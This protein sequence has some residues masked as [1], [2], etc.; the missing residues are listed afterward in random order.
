VVQFL[1]SDSSAC[2]VNIKDFHVSIRIIDPGGEGKIVDD[3]N[4]QLP[5]G[6]V[7]VHSIGHPARVV[8]N[9]IAEGLADF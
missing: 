5:S 4:L 9:G 6:I 2:T 8:A 1:F 3:G 7:K